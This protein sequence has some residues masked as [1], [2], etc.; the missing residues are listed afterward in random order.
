M[1]GNE[2]T[3]PDRKKRDWV[4]ATSR[5]LI[6]I[7]IFV[8]GAVL[9]Y[10]KD[11]GDQASKDFQLESEVLKQVTS[12]D[13]DEQNI[14]LIRLRIL[15]QRKSKIASEIQQVVDDQNRIKS[16]S[17][18]NAHDILVQDIAADTKQNQTAPTAQ[19]NK[20]APKVYIQIANENQRADA[21]Q[22]AD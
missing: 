11:R 13:L 18:K 2:K 22:L 1:D 19:S 16:L 7:L 14:G 9:T 6:P 12:K 10:Q 21:N 4:D 15:Q 8:A 5:L 17:S 20:Q 3:G